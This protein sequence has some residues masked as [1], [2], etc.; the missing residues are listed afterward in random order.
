M[1][2]HKRIALKLVVA[3]ICGLAPALLIL[4]ATWQAR[5]QNEQEKTDNF[6]SLVI[7]RTDRFIAQASGAVK[8]ISVL[9]MVPC[10]PEHIAYMRRVMLQTVSI[11]KVVYFENGGIRCSSWG[12]GGSI[13]GAVSIR[14]FDP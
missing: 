4:L 9:R 8:S 1:A 11:E 13:C 10:S 3:F 2:R 6:S 5:I 12:G 7:S 14:F